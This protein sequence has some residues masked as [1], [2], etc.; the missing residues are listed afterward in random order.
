MQL[1]HHGIL[2]SKRGKFGGY[3]LLLPADRITFGQILRII[4]GPIAPLACL[5]HTAYRRCPDCRSEQSCR[6]RRVFAK[7]AEQLRAILDHTTIADAIAEVWSANGPSG[8]I[9]QV[10]DP[11]PKV[12]VCSLK[13]DHNCKSLMILVGS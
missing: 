6:V 3:E 1:K 2:E 13:A 8:T 9:I 4:E 5:S 10:K 11:L 12:S 7:V